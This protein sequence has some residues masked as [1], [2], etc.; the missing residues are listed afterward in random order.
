MEWKSS[1]IL[2]G[3]YSQVPPIRDDE[4][5]QRLCLDHSY[6][7]Y[8]RL[9]Q[10]P[11]GDEVQCRRDEASRDVDRAL[12][13]MED[14]CRDGDWLCSGGQFGQASET[15]PV[16]PVGTRAQAQ[17]GTCLSLGPSLILLNLVL[18]KVKD[19]YNEPDIYKCST[20]YSNS[21]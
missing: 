4:D 8:R 1:L 21:R 16:D 10:S 3:K 14:L 11:D 17:T 18:K 15:S 19:T 12:A 7:P 2:A 13:M 5:I 9:E 20:P 6:N